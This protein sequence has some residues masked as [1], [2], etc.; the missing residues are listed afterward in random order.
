MKAN[1]IIYAIREKLKEYT[2]DTRYTDDYIMYLVRINRAVLIRREYS[3]LQRTVDSEV[4]Q[5][6]C[7]NTEEV[8]ESL[9]PECSTYYNNDN[10]C[11]II[12]TIEQVPFTI[13]LHNKN[14]IHRVVVF[15]ENNPSNTQIGRPV[16]YI[17]AE[18][19]VYA[20]SGDFEFNQIFAFLLPDGHM[21]LKSRTGI[22]RTIDKIGITAA[23]EN[24]DDASI[25]PDCYTGK[26]SCFN[27][28]EDRYP[29]KA[30]MES[31]IISEIVSELVNLKKLPA[32]EVNNSKADIN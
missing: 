5:T 25:F 22:H 24:P 2:D 15:D 1:E 32:D 16:N 17:S 26:T 21:Y 11:S 20:G 18:R 28:L 8:N 7:M 13:E 10:Q 9:C 6:F 19:A 4:L 3:N 23:L 12:R 29:V 31:I 30:W 27:I 14:M